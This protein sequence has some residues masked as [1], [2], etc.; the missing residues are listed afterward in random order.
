M[1]HLL[2][3]QMKILITGAAGFI[4]SHT[5]ERLASLGHT[6]V[7]YDNFSGYYDESLKRENEQS[8]LKKGI[9][10][11]KSDLAENNISAF[12]GTDF[13]YIFHLA[14][15]PG[16]A[17]DVTFEDYLKNNIIA[18]NNLLDFASQNKSLQLFAN[19]STSSVYGI[20]ATGREDVIPA[21]VSYYGV[22]KLAAEQLAL[23]KSREHAF[24]VCSLRLYSVYGPRER[25]DKLFSKLITAGLNDTHFELFEGSEAH[26][27]SF[28]FVDDI[29][30]GIVSVIGKENIL[31]GEIINLGNE[32][33][34]T[35]QYGIDCIKELLHTDIHTLHIAKRR[36]DQLHTKADITKARHLLNYDPQTSLKEG[37]KKQIEWQQAHSFSK[38]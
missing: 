15:Q 2:L 13:D 25:P 3:K 4:G 19:I 38:Q 37:L 11:I 22:T 1:D 7:G 33:E 20:N 10:I 26:I 12:A 31:N 35:T 36:G 16:I 9:Q 18:T 32:T 23:K 29:V 27:R 5:A 30:D 34:C 24:N 14:A 21:P 17:A 28:T 6:V 8:L